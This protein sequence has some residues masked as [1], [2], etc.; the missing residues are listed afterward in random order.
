MSLFDIWNQAHYQRLV[1][2]ALQTK[3]EAA[4]PVVRS[5][6]TTVS[7]TEDKIRMERAEIKA[8]GYAKPKAFGATPPIFVPKLRYSE[9]EV[10]LLP[11]HEMSPIDER[12]MRKLLSKD[13]DIK[14]R[15]GADQVLRAQALATRNE[16]GWDVLTMN[17]ILTGQLTALFEDEN[18]AGLVIDYQ[19]DPTHF[20][21]VA[22]PWNALT[23]SKPIDA[24]RA[25]QL[26]LSNDT[27]DYGIHFWMSSNTARGI[28][29]ST[30]AKELLTGSERAQYIPE[31]ADI[32]KRMYEPERVQFHIT[33]SGY[34]GETYDRGLN[35]H[36]K[37]IPD[38][39]VIVTTEDPF[40]GEPLIE[41]F[42]GL[43]GVPVSEFQP[44]DFRAGQQNW[45]LLDTKS[46][47][48]YYHNA[49]TRIP[50]INKPECIVIMDTGGVPA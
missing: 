10:E 24:M 37:F 40:E 30:Q 16:L 14:K 42:D 33:D 13:A 23:T 17:A 36:T 19:Y 35:A 22:A 7:T 1:T 47:T 39:K 11:I 15:A 34:R 25:V 18:G 50:R 5:L 48:T 21:S 38:G 41:V 45:I 4:S 6:Y 31:R 32:V 26:Q 46:L 20:V 44:P 2:V 3:L 27:G 9:L 49:S 43:T 29:E 28:F 12:T 8:F